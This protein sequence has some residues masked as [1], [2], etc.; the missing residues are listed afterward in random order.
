MNKRKTNQ[1]NDPEIILA[2]QEIKFAKILAGNDKKLRDKTLRRL[3]KWLNYRS[4]SSMGIIT[5][6]RYFS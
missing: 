6:T 1:L 5:F 2:A 3:Q 4:Q